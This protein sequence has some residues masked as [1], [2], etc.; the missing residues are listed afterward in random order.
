MAV[1][2]IA[3]RAPMLRSQI[4]EAWDA[5]MSESLERHFMLTGDGF[6][7]LW[8]T[9]EEHRAVSTFKTT[10][11]WKHN[12]GI[13]RVDWIPKPRREKSVASV[14]KPVV[15]TSNSGASIGKLVYLTPGPHDEAPRYSSKDDMPKWLQ[16]AVDKHDESF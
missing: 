7:S 16:T 15:S 1:P 2:P 4:H 13:E 8:L 3:Y 6:D 14:S 11:V 9:E 5:K 10:G 12:D